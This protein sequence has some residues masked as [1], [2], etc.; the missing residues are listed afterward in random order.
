MAVQPTLVPDFYMGFHD[1]RSFVAKTANY[2]I[3][4]A[5]NG[6]WF[7]NGGSTGAITFTLPAIAPLY[8]FGF[9]AAA[10][11]NVTIS[12]K[13]GSNIIAPG[14]IAASNVAF[15]TPNCRLGG[16]V[17][18]RTGSDGTKWAVIWHGAG[19]LTIS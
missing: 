9:H 11:Q 16:F 7:S 12:S 14:N 17:T 5:D 6:S 1:F 3:L 15:Q 19:A 2:Q 13:E 10:D 4:I 18:L 8:K